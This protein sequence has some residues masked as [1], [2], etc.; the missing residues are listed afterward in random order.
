LAKE[1]RLIDGKARSPYVSGEFLR[2][3]IGAEMRSAARSWIVLLVIALGASVPSTHA[4][5]ETTERVENYAI[6]GS[7]GIELYRSIGERGPKVGVA[8]AIAHTNFKLTWSRKYEPQDDGG[9]TLV[10]ARPKLIITYTLPRPAGNL[11]PAVKKQWDT[12]IEGVRLHEEEHGVHIKEML[13]E[14]EAATIGFSATD[15]PKCQKVRKAIIPL[16]SQASVRQR[17][18]SRDFDRVEMANGGNM[19]RLI[20]ALVNGE[21]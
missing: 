20:L 8:R 7:S 12:F 9:C 16:L 10:S 1:L 18:R 4:S 6:S 13:A 19:H 11:P 17:E 3:T 5:A 21:Q 14:I 15:D 2:M